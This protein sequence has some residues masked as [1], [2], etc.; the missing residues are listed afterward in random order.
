MARNTADLPLSS[1]C[2]SLELQ[3]MDR[4][5]SAVFLDMTDFSSTLQVYSEVDEDASAK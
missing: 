3:F 2:N 4:G 5:S 1:N